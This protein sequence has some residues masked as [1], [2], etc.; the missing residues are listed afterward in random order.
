MP[1]I[2]KRFS[3]FRSKI[4][5]SFSKSLSVKI[6]YLGRW[7][8]CGCLSVCVCVCTEPCVVHDSVESVSNGKD[9]AALELGPDGGLDEI[10]RLQVNSGCRFIQNEDPGLPQESSSQTHQLPLAHAEDT[11]AQDALRPAALQKKNPKHWSRLF[12]SA[13]T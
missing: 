3:K 1:F 10:I 13:P 5:E 11:T 6:A 12:P 8:F 2:S 7:R 4:L 9:S